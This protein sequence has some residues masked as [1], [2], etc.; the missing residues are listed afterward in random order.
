VRCIFVCLRFILQCALKRSLAITDSDLPHF[1]TRQIKC[2]DVQ[3]VRLTRMISSRPKQDLSGAQS[4]LANLQRI[5]D[6]L[7]DTGCAHQ[8]PSSQDIDMD[9]SDGPE[10]AANPIN[11]GYPGHNMHHLHIMDAHTAASRLELKRATT[12]PA[13]SSASRCIDMTFPDLHGAGTGVADAIPAFPAFPDAPAGVAAAYCA[14]R[15]SQAWRRGDR[16]T[17]SQSADWAAAASEDPFHFDWPHWSATSTRPAAGGRS[18]QHSG[19]QDNA[20]AAAAA[21][22]AGAARAGFH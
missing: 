20:G 18:P 16:I 21:A 11:T 12:A 9:N 13:G 10:K 14:G 1:L 6:A 19:L 17:R 8:P 4:E 7:L 15:P 3:I 22:S 5:R 2:L